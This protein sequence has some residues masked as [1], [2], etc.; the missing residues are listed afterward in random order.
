MPSKSLS[1]HD[2]PTEVR[3]L[4]YHYAV[5][6]DYEVIRPDDPDKPK[7]RPEISHTTAFLK[8]SKLINIEAN[9]VFYASHLFYCDNI[10]SVIAFTSKIGKQNASHIKTLSIGSMYYTDWEA[11]T[12]AHCEK[13]ALKDAATTLRRFCT[14]LELLDF[15]PEAS[16]HARYCRTDD[17]PF[18]YWTDNAFVAVKALT[19][20]FPWLNYVSYEHWGGRA[21]VRM[22]SIE[23]MQVAGE[24]RSAVHNLGEPELIDLQRTH[25]STSMRRLWQF[26]PKR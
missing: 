1:F 6:C 13:D 3:N 20:A 11:Q 16:D 9:P 8:V 26:S 21:A 23:A 15:V 22:T 2:L 5:I 25:P 10:S 4:I 24:V 14:G 18:N 17:V 19:V 12:S 7:Y